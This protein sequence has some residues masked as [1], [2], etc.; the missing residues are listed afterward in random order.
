MMLG[1]VFRIV[2]R[3]AKK[4]LGPLEFKMKTVPVGLSEDSADVAVEMDHVMAWNKVQGKS[5][6]RFF[7]LYEDN[8]RC[9]RITMQHLQHVASRLLCGWHLEA[10]YKTK[11]QQQDSPVQMLAHDSTSVTYSV[12]CF[13]LLCFV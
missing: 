12:L 8:G 6:K 3:V 4:A 9:V 2:L 11:L 7:T 10:C 13:V 1:M 5:Q